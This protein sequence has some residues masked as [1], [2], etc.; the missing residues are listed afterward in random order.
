MRHCIIYGS[1]RFREPPI[2]VWSDG[3]ECHDLD[4]RLDL[5]NGQAE[6]DWGSTSEGSFQLAVAI[7]SLV[8]QDD[9]IVQIAAGPFTTWVTSQLRRPGW[10]ISSAHV[11]DW[12]RRWQAGD[13]RC[14]L[15]Y[16][17]LPSLM[18]DAT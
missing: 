18:G 6:F 1:R 4:P 16:P 9:A 5:H 12:F 8:L 15:G 11:Q 2:I 10:T 14:P 13:P 3:E 7:L 17:Y